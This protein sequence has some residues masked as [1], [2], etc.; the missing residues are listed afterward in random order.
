MCPGRCWEWVK[1][2]Q[3][4]PQFPAAPGKEGQPVTKQ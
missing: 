4:W 2:A 3:M 1:E